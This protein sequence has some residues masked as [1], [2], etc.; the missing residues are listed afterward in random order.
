M[1]WDLAQT[2]RNAPIESGK[3]PSL[4]TV[5][6]GLTVFGIPEFFC[7]SPPSSRAIPT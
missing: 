6:V 3:T 4:V 7:P 1:N 2:N 5:H